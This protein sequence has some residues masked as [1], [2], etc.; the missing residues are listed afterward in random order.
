MDSP[1]FASEITFNLVANKIKEQM[2]KYE[3]DYGGLMNVRVDLLN[4]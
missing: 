1:H 2:K 3:K 4:E